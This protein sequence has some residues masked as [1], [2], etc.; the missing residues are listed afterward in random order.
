M[1]SSVGRG[2]PAPSEAAEPSE[3]WSVQGN[4]ELFVMR[5]TCVSDRQARSHGIVNWNE[6]CFRET[7]RCDS[8][9]VMIN[10]LVIQHLRVRQMRN[11]VRAK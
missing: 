2:G 6:N 5:N 1:L 9:F 3:K 7:Q 11:G 8:V 10:D 4:N